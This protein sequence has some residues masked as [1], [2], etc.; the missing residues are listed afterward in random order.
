MK[1]LTL[2]KEIELVVERDLLLREAQ[3]LILLG[4]IELARKAIEKA[5]EL[6]D[7]IEKGKVNG[8]K[9]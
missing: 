3:K 5:A 7:M 6:D 9:N 4:R 1:T 8:N 2:R